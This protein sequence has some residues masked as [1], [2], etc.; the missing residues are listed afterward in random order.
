MIE[1]SLLVLSAISPVFEKMFDEKWK[2]QEKV[3][4]LPDIQPKAFRTF[5]KVLVTLSILLN[6]QSYVLYL[7]PI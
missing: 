5:L 2:G 1:A 4:P 6:T 7:L 3:I